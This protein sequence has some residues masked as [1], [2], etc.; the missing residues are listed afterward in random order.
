MA[1]A[2]EAIRVEGWRWVGIGQEAQARAWGLGRVWPG[3]VA[4]SPE[5]EQ[6]RAELAGRYDE[7]AERHNH[8]ADDLPE[9]VAA[10][11]D[12]IEA[13]LAM[14]EAKEAVFRPEDVARAGVV[15]TLA[16][17]GA[18]RIERGFVRSEDEA[19]PQ[20]VTPVANG[21]AAECVGEMGTGGYLGDTS[22]GGAVTP[23]RCE[24]ELEDKAPALSAALLAELKAHRTAGLQAA[25]TWQPELALRVLLQALATDAFYPR[26]GETIAGFH[27]YLPALTSACPGIGDNPA[28]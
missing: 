18:L 8:D 12:R 19:R 14:L 5:E 28:R 23:V 6:Q 26:Q 9:D 4:L 22:A 2:A 25:I 24:A 21:R 1:A 3:K 27:A 10:E 11:L 16:A 7:L 20:P 17:D 15:L 13:A